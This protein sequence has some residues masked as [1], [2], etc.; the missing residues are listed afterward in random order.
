MHLVSKDA[1][2]FG[3][4]ALLKIFIVATELV[5]FLLMLKEV[6]VCCPLLTLLQ[7]LFKQCLFWSFLQ[8]IVFAATV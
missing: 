5:I 8:K 4:L 1:F 3:S 2:T 6:F 7:T